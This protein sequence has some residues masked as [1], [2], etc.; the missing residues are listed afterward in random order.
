[1][2]KLQIVKHLSQHVMDRMWMLLVEK[3]HVQ[4]PPRKTQ[5]FSNVKISY[6]DVSLKR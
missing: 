3:R 6:Q 4:T 1:M 2:E 5:L